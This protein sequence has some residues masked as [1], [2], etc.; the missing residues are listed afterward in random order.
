MAP[1]NG[2]TL[3]EEKAAQRTERP[4]RTTSNSIKSDVLD[5]TL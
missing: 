2:R 1:G 3:Y 4:F 5:L